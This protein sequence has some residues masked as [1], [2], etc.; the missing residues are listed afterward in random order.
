MAATTTTAMQVGPVF[1]SPLCI[2]EELA[3][4]DLYYLYH[5][6][7]SPLTAMVRALVRDQFGIGGSRN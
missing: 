3:M 7:P 1:L 6:S 5:P 4:I 2:S